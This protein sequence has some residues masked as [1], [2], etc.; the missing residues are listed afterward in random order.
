MNVFTGI[1]E[2]T[3]TIKE[4]KNFSQSI[5]LGIKPDVSSFEVKEGDSVSVDGVCLTLERRNSSI[6]YFT[7]VYETISR[8]TLGQKNIGSKVN[9]ERALFVSQRIDG[10]IVLGHVD[11]TGKISSINKIGNSIVFSF[12]IPKDLLC[13]CAEKGSIAID[14]ISL[15]IS[16]IKG[17]YVD[18]SIVPY[19]LEKTTL[20]HKKIGDIVNIECDVIARYIKRLLES[21]PAYKGGYELISNSKE[22]KGSKDILSFLERAGF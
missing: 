1:I 11:G 13:L 4:I 21:N 10:H 16:Q 3:G 5:I 18:V 2:T 6:L 7:A 20:S 9:L 22:N 14:G 15:T 19:T 8:S 12:K 17:E